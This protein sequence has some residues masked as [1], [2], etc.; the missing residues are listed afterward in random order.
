VAGHLAGGADRIDRLP[1][2]HDHP[3]TVA[4]PAAIEALATSLSL[5]LV[6]FAGTYV[7][8]ATHS[9][10]NFGEHRTHTDALYF[11]VTVFSRSGS[12]TS[13]LRPRRR[14]WWS[15]AR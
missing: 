6:L 2:P 13:P 9:A 8:M 12:A 14:G 3:V 11:T 15:P 1:G 4:E 5:V 7:A 10:G